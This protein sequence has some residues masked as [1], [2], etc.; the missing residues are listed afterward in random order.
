[1]ALRYTQED[2][3]AALAQSTGPV[4]WSFNGPKTYGYS[5]LM[6]MREAAINRWIRAMP[7]DEDS[8]ILRAAYQDL[9]EV[10]YFRFYEGDEDEE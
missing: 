8:R 9:E 4:W 3:R 6:A 5:D 7:E 10:G 1:M 2:L